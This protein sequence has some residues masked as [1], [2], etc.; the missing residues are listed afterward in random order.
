MELSRV[1]LSQLRTE[2]GDTGQG[3]LSPLCPVA[4]LAFLCHRGLPLPC[5][6]NHYKISHRRCHLCSRRI[7]GCW[8]ARSGI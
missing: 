2:G 5:R 4:P 1:G 8:D 6:I 7:G 3:R